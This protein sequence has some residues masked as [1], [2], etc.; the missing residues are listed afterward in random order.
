M[1]ANI[2]YVAL[3]E[4]ST[5]PCSERILMHLSNQFADYV[6]PLLETAFKQIASESIWY[7]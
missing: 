7:K 5:Q 2:L 6:M 3:I 1:S 4:Q